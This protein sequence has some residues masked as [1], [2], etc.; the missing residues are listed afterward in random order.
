MSKTSITKKHH[1]TSSDVD[2]LRGIATQVQALLTTA[3]HL[4][5]GESVGTPGLFVDNAGTL[6]LEGRVLVPF[7][8]TGCGTVFQ[9]ALT[10]HEARQLSLKLLQATT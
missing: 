1:Q 8:L 2:Q 9:C 10:P 6:D 7:G 4:R 3:N 5:H